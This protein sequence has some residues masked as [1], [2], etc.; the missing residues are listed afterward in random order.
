MF[1]SIGIDKMAIEKIIKYRDSMGHLH[2]DEEEA[3]LFEEI[4]AFAKL[5]FLLK[6]S[7]IKDLE[8]RCVELENIL[9]IISLNATIIPDP[10][11]KETTDIYSV[12][13]DDIEAARA[14]LRKYRRPS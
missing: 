8:E 9:S 12:P 11:M 1:L 10:A 14:L 5:A 4:S 2:D 6:R 13:I 7:P 3:R